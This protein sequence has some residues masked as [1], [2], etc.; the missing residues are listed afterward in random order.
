VT[1]GLFHCPPTLTD[2]ASTPRSMAR[3]MPKATP[4]TP[5]QNEAT[6]AYSKLL[7]EAAVRLTT[8]QELITGRFVISD[9]LIVEFGYLQLR[10]L[11]EVVA[12]CCLVAHGDIEATRSSKLQKE[13]AADKLMKMLE[14]LHGNFYPRPV[15]VIRTSTGHHIDRIAEGFLTKEELLRLYHECG[16]RLHRG[17]LA[18]FRSSAPRVN[19]ADLAKLRG[20]LSKFLVLLNSHHVASRDNNAHFICFLSHEQVAG[21]ALVVLATSALP[22]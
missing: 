15:T 17:S 3:R 11:C 7:D 20:W 13:Y 8:I 21:K 1:Q 6:A 4:P 22:D 16:D 12:L 10:M 14:P 2:N 18:K 5:Q 9:P 19:E